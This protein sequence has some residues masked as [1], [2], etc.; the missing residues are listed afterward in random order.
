MSLFKGSNVK[1]INETSFVNKKLK[2]N[3]LGFSGAIVLFYAH[4]CPHCKNIADDVKKFA[5]SMGT[6]IKVYAVESKHEKLISKFNIQGFPTFKFARSSDGSLVSA[7][8]FGR[9]FQS[10]LNFA[11]SK[12]SV[13]KTK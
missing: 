1:E 13:C 11:C 8:N 12:A 4:W 3:L 9:D 2:K 10:M 7:D 5:R 6:S